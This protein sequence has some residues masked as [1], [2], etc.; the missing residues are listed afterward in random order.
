MIGIE[1][2]LSEQG[3]ISGQDGVF[4]PTVSRVFFSGPEF[5]PT[6]QIVFVVWREIDLFFSAAILAQLDC[7]IS[8]CVF[9]PESSED[10]A[11][12]LIDIK[13]ME[14]REE[15]SDMIDDDDWK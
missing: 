8:Q 4:G 5:S 13:K 10:N 6:G 15:T 14:L 7:E 1:S 12:V 9:V 2:W 3:P 11:I